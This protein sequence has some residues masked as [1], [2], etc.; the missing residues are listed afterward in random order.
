MVRN[1]KGTA[2]L[3]PNVALALH[4]GNLLQAE[5]TGTTP[6]HRSGGDDGFVCRGSCELPAGELAEEVL[7][8]AYTALETRT[9]RITPH[10]MVFYHS[11]THAQFMQPRRRVNARILIPQRRIW[12]SGRFGGGLQ[13]WTR[14]REKPGILRDHDYV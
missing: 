2:N 6:R 1:S 12:P 3:G 4:G 10:E 9:G 7:M 11:L 8:L 5:S 13:P 14:L